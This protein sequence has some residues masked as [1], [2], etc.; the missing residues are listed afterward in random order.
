MNQI[1]VLDTNYQEDILFKILL[2]LEVQDKITK[3][4]IELSDGSI[5]PEKGEETYYG[6]IKDEIILF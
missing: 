6:K 3:E 5:V 4:L 2:P 1:S